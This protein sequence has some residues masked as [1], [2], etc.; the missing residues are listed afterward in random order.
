MV[1]TFPSFLVLA[2]GISNFINGHS[3]IVAATADISSTRVSTFTTKSAPNATTTTATSTKASSS[4]ATSGCAAI[5]PFLASPANT[6]DAVPASWA[7]NCLKSVPL[8]VTLSSAFVD[9]IE[10]YYQFQSTLAYLKDPPTGY[11]LPGA[12]ILGGL[13][14]IKTKVQRGVYESQWEFEVDLWALGNIL[15]HDFHMNLPLPLI[16]AFNFQTIEG[17]LISFSSDGL[18]VPEVFFKSDLDQVYN[19]TSDLDWTPSGLVSINGQ[20]TST[21]L[22]LLGQ[23]MSPFQDPDAIYNQVFYSLPAAAYNGGSGL[24]VIG[25]YK[26]GFTDDTY[27]YEFANRTSATFDNIAT[28]SLDFSNITSGLDLF[29]LVDLPPIPE[30]TPTTASASATLAVTS[31]VGY[32]SPVVIHS[33]GYTSGY[34]LENT[35]IAVLAI[36][37]FI[38]AAESDPMASEEQQAVI[39]KFLEKCKT[40]S[41]TKLIIDLATNGGGD[42]LN[43]IDAFK[44]FFPSLVPYAATRMRATPAV[45]F[46]GTLFSTDGIYNTT[47]N[48]VYQTQGSLDV[49]NKP[50]PSWNVEGGPYLIHG[51]NFTAQ[52]R[53]NFSNPVVRSGLNITGYGDNTETPDQFFDASNIVMLMDGGCGSTCA[54]F[55]ELMKSQG[56]VRSIVVGGRAQNGPMQGV[57]G[58]KGAQVLT[59]GDVANYFSAVPQAIEIYNEKG[60]PTSSLPD[61]PD[62]YVPDTNDDAPLG[63]TLALTSG[64]RFNLRSNMHD[65]DKTQTPLQFVY[66]PANCRLF[67]KSIDFYDITQLWARVADVTW[68]NAPCVA[69]SSINPNNTLPTGPYDTV[70]FHASVMSKVQQTPQPGLILN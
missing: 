56:N 57:G 49:N 20:N 59:F 47:S 55:A 22:N 39:T 64:G 7:L 42:V 24:F 58:S 38:D 36:Q 65:S 16:N 44:Q 8:N 68:D 27:I 37:G 70:P 31:L 4:P 52:I 62:F 66:E 21:Y 33:D 43:G 32:P 30:P 15:A 14:E 40:A 28:T 46:L 6:V 10:P 48:S 61:V 12:D 11:L 67:Y 17:P 50:F 1:K 51:D 5:G 54:V 9:Y 2:S 60:F 41:M 35:T 19:A 69:G 25:G 13:A 23:T 26:Y 45:N 3:N 29:N 63:T 18:T 53:S 34:F